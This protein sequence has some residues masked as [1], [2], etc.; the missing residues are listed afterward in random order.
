MGTS[1][2]RVQTD[3]QSHQERTTRQFWWKGKLNLT[4]E[5]DSFLMLGKTE[6]AK[7][8]TVKLKSGPLCSCPACKTQSHFAWV[9]RNGIRL[10]SIPVWLQKCQSRQNDRLTNLRTVND[11]WVHVTFVHRPRFDGCAA[12]PHIHRAF[13]SVHL[14]SA[15][16]AE[17]G[18]CDKSELMGRVAGNQNAS[19]ANGEASAW[20]RV[21]AVIRWFPGSER[22][23]SAVKLV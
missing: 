9:T 2:Q 22:K 19:R 12:R 14:N 16:E 23:R 18:V 5:S 20:S 4:S 21:Q 10:S 17:Y 11:S 6:T 13:H 8:T 3:L 1:G 15:R 7:S